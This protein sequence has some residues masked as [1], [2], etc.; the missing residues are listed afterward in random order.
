MIVLY[1][2]PGIELVLARGGSRRRSLGGDG[3]DGSVCGGLHDSR[4]LAAV[5]WWWLLLTVFLFI[6]VQAEEEQPGGM[7][8]SAN[9]ILRSIA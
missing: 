7:G 1:A 4:V 6:Q 5:R 8:I 9:D 3:I 2:G